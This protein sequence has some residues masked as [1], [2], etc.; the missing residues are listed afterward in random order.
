MPIIVK[1]NLKEQEDFEI[2]EL[3]PEEGAVNQDNSSMFGSV[4]G[5]VRGVDDKGAANGISKDEPKSNESSI[6]N[7]RQGKR[8]SINT[9][10]LMKLK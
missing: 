6:L 3:I 9:S 7:G 2:T 4:T 10:G 8:D 1:N 5:K